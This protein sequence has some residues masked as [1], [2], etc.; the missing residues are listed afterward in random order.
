MEEKKHFYN[1][2]DSKENCSAC[3]VLPGDV[4]TKKRIREVD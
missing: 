1:P 3:F 2:P 4:Y